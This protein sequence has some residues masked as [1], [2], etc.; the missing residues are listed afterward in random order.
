MTPEHLLTRYRHL[1]GTLAAL[2]RSSHAVGAVVETVHQ[3]ASSLF[4]AQVT[5]LALLTPSGEW[6]WDLYEGERRYRQHLPYSPDGVME[7]A[8]HGGPLHIGDIEAY[9]AAHPQ[10][11]RRLVSDEVVILDLRGEAEP[12]P[13]PDSPPT[14]SMLFV[15]LEVRG[16]PAGVLSLQS[17][18]PHAFDDTDLQFLEL[19]AQ[20]VSIA[21]ENAALR[22]ELERASHTDPLTGLP[23][24]RAFGEAAARALAASAAGEEGP[25]SLVVLDIHHFKHYNDTLGHAAGDDVLCQVGEVLRRSAEHRGAAYRLGGDEFALLLRLPAAA[26]GAWAREVGAALRAA[27]WP[28]GVEGVRLQAGA[29]AVTSDLTVRE[30][31]S[32]ADA[33]LYQAKR[34]RE[35]GAGVE[36]GVDL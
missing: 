19:L 14:R 24:R 30:W 6:R 35:P 25:L 20:H 34:A 33:R 23:N 16:R 5:L 10:R 11:A 2:A 3:Q 29:S 12:V 18:A 17:Y 4:A 32:R 36:W 21:L 26:L 31:L 9:L 15:P 8:L 1:V 22:E 27:S 7:T 28:P 13:P